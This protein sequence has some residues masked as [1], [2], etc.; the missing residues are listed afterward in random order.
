MINEARKALDNIT[1]IKLGKGF[2]FDEALGKSVIESALFH[3]VQT[4][5]EEIKARAEEFIAELGISDDKEVDKEVNN[6]QASLNILTEGDKKDI[7]TFA[8]KLKN[9]INA[10]HFIKDN[11]ESIFDMK[12]EEAVDNIGL[13]SLITRATFNDKDYPVTITREGGLDL[14]KYKEFNEVIKK[15]IRSSVIYNLDSAIHEFKEA[16]E[17]FYAK[18]DVGRTISAND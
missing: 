12:T 8:A 18:R 14:K 5:K 17:N 2:P 11:D 6:F 10:L 16:I 9:V 3:T 4:V 7:E 13:K 15:A 1:T